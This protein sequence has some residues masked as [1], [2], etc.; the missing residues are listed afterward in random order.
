MIASIVADGRLD[1]AGRAVR[2]R[3]AQPGRG[4]HPG[5]GER[6]LGPGRPFP[7]RLATILFLGTTLAAGGCR[8][9]AA[10]GPSTS[11]PV[12]E[13]GVALIPATAPRIAEEVRR[14]GARVVLVNVWATWCEP[15]KEEMPDLLRLRRTLAP[16]GLRLV[17]VSGD[18]DTERRQV[19]RFLAAEGVDFP[20]FI[21]SGDDAAFIDGLDPRWSG[22]LPATFVYDSVGHLRRFWEGKADFATLERRVLDV[23]G[24]ADRR[25]EDSHGGT[26]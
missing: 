3:L 16:R 10:A 6:F 7:R 23:L 12:G 18:F 22:A 24:T 20:S 11:P 13:S 4:L 17:L 21:K 15:C 19:V 25:P 26:R 2:G 8:G 5:S 1:G 14:P 9:N